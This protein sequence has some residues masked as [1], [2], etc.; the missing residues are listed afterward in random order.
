MILNNLSFPLKHPRTN[1]FIFHNK[2]C[3][4]PPPH[5]KISSI[6]CFQDTWDSWYCSPDTWHVG[7]HCNNLWDVCSVVTIYDFI[8]W[9][10]VIWN[11]NNT[12]ISIT[13]EMSGPGSFGSILFVLL[14]NVHQFCGHFHYFI[15][16]CCCSE[17]MIFW[18]FCVREE[19]TES[20]SLI[21]GR[22]INNLEHR[23]NLTN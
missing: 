20:G 23:V 16:T 14:H 5:Y 4:Y 19:N 11:N 6:N 7:K 21:V 9:W 12:N 13:V 18:S 3:S 8:S 2:V 22:M 10:F 1:I 15:V 17:N